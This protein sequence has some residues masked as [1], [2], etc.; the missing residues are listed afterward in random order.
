MVDAALEQ[1]EHQ[2]EA[3]TVTLRMQD[4][5]SD[6]SDYH[7]PTSDDHEGGS[8]TGGVADKEI[9]DVPPTTE[10][11]AKQALPSM[12]IQQPLEIG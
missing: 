3:P 9:D 8:S 6:D 5:D 4:S 1:A 10:T 7:D 11:L 2:Y 12:S